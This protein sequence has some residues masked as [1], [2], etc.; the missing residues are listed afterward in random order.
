MK[1]EPDTNST[2]NTFSRRNFFRLGSAA[3]AGGMLSFKGTKAAE[4]A[5]APTADSAIKKYHM[6]GRTGFKASD[7]S[8]GC[9]WIKDSNVIRYCYDKG[10]NYFDSAE[11]YGNGDSE[12]RIG[13]AL[14]F[15]DRKKVFVVTK[16]VVE[17]ND[18]EQVILDRFRKSLEHL[19]TPYV[20]AY[21]HHAVKYEIG[22]AHV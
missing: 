15:M 13:Q 4:S 16:T 10:V 22:R 14:K 17:K 1:K 19:K 2:D 9:P 18:T 20:D 8:M 3:L 11:S 12:R 5:A 6:L 21:F 7:I